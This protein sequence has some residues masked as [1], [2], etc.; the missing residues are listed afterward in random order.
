MLKLLFILQLTWSSISFSQDKSDDL[1]I[2]K[3]ESQS[4]VMGMFS[5]Y[6]DEMSQV[7]LFANYSVQ[8]MRIFVRKR[9]KGKFIGK[10]FYNFPKLEDFTCHWLVDEEALPNILS[11]AKKDEKLKGYAVI[12]LLIVVLGFL[13]SSYFLRDVQGFS[14]RF[15]LGSL[16][17]FLIFIICSLAFYFAFPKELDPTLRIVKQIFL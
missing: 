4:F 5:K 17:N 8:E 11:I 9:S 14:K 15:L 13:M 1:E 7:N 6:L 12:S 16:H 2:D 10:V 3:V